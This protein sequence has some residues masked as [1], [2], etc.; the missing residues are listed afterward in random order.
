M[1]EAQ[2][3]PAP[4]ALSEVQTVGE[5][6]AALAE[7]ASAAGGLSDSAKEALAAAVQAFQAFAAEAMGGEPGPAEEEGV[8]SPEQGGSGA[9]PV[10]PGGRR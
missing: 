6:L 7:K 10:G 8:T 3:A 4:D 9:V 1:P 5:G 2:G